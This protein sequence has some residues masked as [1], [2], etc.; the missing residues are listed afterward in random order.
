LP[1]AEWKSVVINDFEA[2]VAQKYPEIE[3]IKTQLYRAGA[4]FA[5]MSGSGSAVFGIFEKPVRLDDL[6]KDNQ[7]FYGA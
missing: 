7:V 4:T 1:P 3:E 2:S 6:E 5:S